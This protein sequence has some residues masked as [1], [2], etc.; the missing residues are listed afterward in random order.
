MKLNVWILRNSGDGIYKDFLI[1]LGSISV[2][3]TEEKSE[4]RWMSEGAAMD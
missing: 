4:D 3:H 2:F 1:R